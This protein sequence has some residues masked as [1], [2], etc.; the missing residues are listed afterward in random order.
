MKKYNTQALLVGFQVTKAG[1]PICAFSDPHGKRPYERIIFGVKRNSFRQYSNPENN[2][3]FMS[4]PSAVHSHKP[5][6]C[7]LMK[8]YIPEDAN[9]LEIFARYLLPGWTSYGNEVLK[10]QHFSLYTKVNESQHGAL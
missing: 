3:V 10:L 1:K 8:D 2:K 7:E 9:C 6:V 5:P 4:V